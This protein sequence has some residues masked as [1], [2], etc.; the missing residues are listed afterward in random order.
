MPVKTMAMPRWSAAAITSGSLTEPP[1]WMTAV[2]PAATTVS[3]PSG[4][5]KKAS[6]ATTQPG[7]GKVAFIAPNLG[8]V[9]AAHLACAYANGL[10]VACVDNGVRR[11]MLGRG[12][13]AK[14]S[15]ASSSSV[16]LRAVTIFNSAAVMWP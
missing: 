15:A 8:R 6:E 5:G 12:R 4:K 10:A 13:Q 3:S 9:D 16:G 1:G 14:S 11:D 2:A 7:S